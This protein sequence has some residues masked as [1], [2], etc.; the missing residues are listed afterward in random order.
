MSDGLEVEREGIAAF[1]RLAD[2]VAGLQARLDGLARDLA[3]EVATAKLAAD[4]AHL[5]AAATEAAAKRQARTLAA[6]IGGAAFA[7]ILAAGA[8]GYLL[9]R[10]SGWDAGQAAG[11]AKAADE[12]AAASWANS[13]DGRLAW[14]MDRSGSLVALA[15]CASP[16]WQTERRGGRRVCYP[17]P[18]KDGSLYGWALP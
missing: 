4:G 17:R 5:A 7:G 6:W 1:T 8:V 15:G 13:E 9:G 14:A 10:S 16:G 2:A 12:K 3:T 18:A 11:Y